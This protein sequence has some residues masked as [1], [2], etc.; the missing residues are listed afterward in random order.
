VLDILVPEIVLQGAGIVA[1]VG[2]LE[3][4]S[5]PQHVWMDGKRHLCGLAEP[6][7]EVMEAKCAHRSTALRDEYISPSRRVFAL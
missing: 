1:I 3:A 6:C 5:V 7:N 2:E 4:A